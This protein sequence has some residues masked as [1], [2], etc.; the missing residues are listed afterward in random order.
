M[1]DLHAESAKFYDLAPNTP[2]DIP[3]YIDRVPS[4][5]SRV[6]ELGCG[7]GRVA[8]PL[9]AHCAA[10]LGLDHSEAMVRIART[11]VMEAG[12]QDRVRFVVGDISLFELGDHFDYIIAP[13]RVLQNLESDAEVVGLLRCIRAHLAPG[14]RPVCQG[15]IP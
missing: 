12:L 10:I 3:F 2:N 1:H 15:G 5:D 13:F 6:L 4:A 14:G 9:A 8:I 11:K 7:T